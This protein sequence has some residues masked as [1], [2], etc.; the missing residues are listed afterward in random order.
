VEL[1]VEAKGETS[2]KDSTKR[3]GKPF[4]TAQVRDHVSNAFYCVASM[5]EPSTEQ[6]RVRV[7][8]ALPGTQ[9]HRKQ[10]AAVR[11][12]ATTLGIGVFWVAP[13]GTIEFEAPWQL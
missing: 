7:A 13:D 5:I 9:G 1:R 3:F 10:V 8:M 4:N 11:E 2:S 6:C 12:A